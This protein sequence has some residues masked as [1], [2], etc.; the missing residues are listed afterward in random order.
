MNEGWFKPLLY[1]MHESCYITH[2]NLV[3][4]VNVNMR[5]YFY[6]AKLRKPQKVFG[7][8]LAQHHFH[9]GEQKLFTH[10]GKR[11]MFVFHKCKPHEIARKFEKFLWFA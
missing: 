6:F 11:P 1:V 2:N 5:L 3:A 8:L 10:L 9:L 4:Y 7:E